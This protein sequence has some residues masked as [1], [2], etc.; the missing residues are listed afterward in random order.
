MVCKYAYSRRSDLSL[1][2]SRM[3]GQYPYCKHQ[4]YC[5]SKGRWEVTDKARTCEYAQRTTKNEI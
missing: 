3:Q 1:V 4:Y 2:C 5:P